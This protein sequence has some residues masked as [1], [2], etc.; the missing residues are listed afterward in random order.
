MFLF[1]DVGQICGN[2]GITEFFCESDVYTKATASQSS[3]GK[4]R[5]RVM[6]TY[7]QVDETLQGSCIDNFL[8]CMKHSNPDKFV[9][10]Q[11]KV[12]V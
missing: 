2:A 1:A 6:R 7:L 8:Q 3:A 12:H 9:D 10:L 5:V 11:T 4:D